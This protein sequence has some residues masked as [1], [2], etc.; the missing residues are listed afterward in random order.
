LSK[1]ALRPTTPGGV[2]VADEDHAGTPNVQQRIHYLGRDNKTKARPGQAR[3]SPISQP[4]SDS[5]FSP[6]NLNHNPN[7]NLNPD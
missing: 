3:F 2:T 1:I 7:L 4:A 5:L 6:L